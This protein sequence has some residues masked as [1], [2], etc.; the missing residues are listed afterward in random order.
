[1]AYVITC[2]HWPLPD[3]VG[4]GHFQQAPLTLNDWRAFS[5]YWLQWTQKKQTRA[6]RDSQTFTKKSGAFLFLSKNI[7]PTKGSS[8]NSS[9]QK[10]VVAPF[11]CPVF[12]KRNENTHTHTH[13]VRLGYLRSRSPYLFWL[14]GWTVV[15]F[16]GW[17][18][19]R[20]FRGLAPRHPN[21]QNIPGKC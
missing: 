16:Y 21:K 15:S 3:F 13:P 20:F 4:G 12:F 7:Q 1:M 14:A 10:I 18:T 6:S 17:S 11:L 8:V 5:I 2:S 9:Q 19:D